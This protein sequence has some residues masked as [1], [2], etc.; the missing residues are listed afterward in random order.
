MTLPTLLVSS[1]K[2]KFSQRRI[3]ANNSARHSAGT[4]L[5]NTSA[6]DAQNTRRRVSLSSTEPQPPQPTIG[7]AASPRQPQSSHCMKRF[8]FHASGCRQFD[9]LVR[10]RAWPAPNCTRCSRR[11]ISRS[12]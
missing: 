1:K 11:S 3:S 5:S 4:S 7:V 2:S 8:E 6:S 10:L 12:A 9:A